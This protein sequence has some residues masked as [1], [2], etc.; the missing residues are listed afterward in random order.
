MSK[1]LQPSTKMDTERR[2]VSSYP[3]MFKFLLSVGVMCAIAGLHG[4]YYNES[5]QE[6][7][8]SVMVL[9]YGIMLVLCSIY[10][11]SVRK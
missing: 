1:K 6:H 3:Q 2:V 10:V 8:L 11:R 4:T 5:V 9:L 7:W